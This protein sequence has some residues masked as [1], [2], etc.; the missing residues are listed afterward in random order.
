MEELKH[1]VSLRVAEIIIIFEIASHFNS[2]NNCFKIISRLVLVYN[3]F[4]ETYFCHLQA[5]LLASLFLLDA[6]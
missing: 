4:E 1:K 5:Y 3:L 6:C 2:I